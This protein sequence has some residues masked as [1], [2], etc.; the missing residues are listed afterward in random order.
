MKKLLALIILGIV[1]GGTF[2]S[3]ESEEILAQEVILPTYGLEPSVCC[4]LRHDFDLDGDGLI[5]FGAGK[6]V[7]SPDEG[8]CPLV[9]GWDHVIPTPY[10]AGLCT[11]DGIKTVADWIKWIAMI[12]TGV[13]MVYAGIMFMTA[14]GNPERVT[15]AK[16]VFL[17]GLIGIVVALGA[18]FF[19]G[20]ARH[21]LGI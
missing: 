2:L 6:V 10:W 14:A 12:V 19:P 5:D 15:K 16:M 9:S 11:L 3:I 7:G 21:F 4:Q 17:Y 13:I 20:L 18:Q 8:Y 1:L